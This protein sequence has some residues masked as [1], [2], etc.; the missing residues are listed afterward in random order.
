MRA[1]SDR[2]LDEIL[3][4]CAQF[5]TEQW[6]TELTPRMK[7]PSRRLPDDR[8]MMRIFAVAIAYSQ[9]ARSKQVSVLTEADEFRHA[10]ADFD[11]AKLAQTK[12]SVI[13][14]RHWASLSS[15]RFR[16]KVERIVRCAQEMC[17]IQKKFGSFAIYL[18]SFKIPQRLQSGDDLDAFWE[19]FD[20]LR[21]DLQQR[22]MPFFRSTTSLLQ[23]LLDLDFD[24][25]KPDLIVMRLA[26]RIGLV[27]RE[28][29]EPHFR[30]A[31]KAIQRYAIERGLRARS[32]DL[33][34]LA[35]GGQ[36]GT[37]DLLSRRFCPPTDPCND[38]SCPLARKGLCKAFSK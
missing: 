2:A 9:N 37:R 6:V 7:Q 15:I 13:L 23:L 4:T 16:G 38:A 36:T 11:P 32:L 26:R 5:S 35:F 20:L 12:P 24:S 28:L 19:R 29:G 14:D 34:M 30:A 17:G 3:L 21:A 18:R 1:A 25:V 10:F 8:G 33:A 22:E 27:E 31:T